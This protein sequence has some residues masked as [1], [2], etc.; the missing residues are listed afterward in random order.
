MLPEGLRRI[1]SRSKETWLFWPLVTL[2]TQT[3]VFVFIFSDK[4][5]FAYQE[6]KKQVDKIAAQIDA[7][8]KQ[9]ADLAE[10]L[11]ILKNNDAALK[12]FSKEFFIFQEQLRILKFEETTS[13]KAELTQENPGFY[14]WQNWYIIA[15]TVIL[16]FITFISWHRN[17]EFQSSME[18]IDEFKFSK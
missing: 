15:S 8:Q 7:L 5:Y 1:Y 16:V 3:M 2:L 17:K 14:S 12:N 18:N 10:R 13:D 11:K 9:K 4:G 6:K